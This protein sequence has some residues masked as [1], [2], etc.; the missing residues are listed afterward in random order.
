MLLLKMAL[1]GISSWGYWEFLR[2]KTDLNVYFLPIVTIAVQCSVLFMGGLLHI[3][4]ET[5]I[6]LH[7][8]GLVLAIFCLVSERKLNWKPYLNWGYVCFALCALLVAVFV[9]GKVFTHIDNFSHWSLVVKKILEVNRYPSFIDTKLGYPYYPL[10]SASYIYFFCRM[11]GTEESMQMLAQGIMMLSAVMPLH[12]FAKKDR[13]FSGLFVA[14]VTALIF[15]YAIRVTE[16]L[17]DTLLPLVGMAAV[18]YGLTAFWGENKPDQQGSRALWPLVPM[19]IW[20]AQIKNSGL[21]FAVLAVV[22]VLPRLPRNR[23]GLQQLVLLV[24]S[25]LVSVFLWRSHCAEV[26]PAGAQEKHTVSVMNYAQTFSQKDMGNAG[27]IAARIVQY[28]MTRDAFWWI[29]IWLAVLGVMSLV[30]LRGRLKKYGY[31]LAGAAALHVIY[32][33]GVVGMFLFSMP[34]EEAMELASIERYVRTLDVAEYY[35]MALYAVSLISSVEG[36]WLG[37]VTAAALCLLCFVTLKNVPDSRPWMTLEH[38]RM[39]ETKIWEYDLQP[40][41]EYF[42]CIPEYDNINNFKFLCNYLL[43][44][45][46]DTQVVKEKAELDRA[47]EY[48]ILINLDEG[49]A[50][51]DAWIAENFPE[52]AGASVVFLP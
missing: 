6:G 52:Q 45:L 30:L 2:K 40:G 36:K 47:R 33:G 7:L 50:L 20:I 13:A 49:N 38:R 34:F 41:R 39:L 19:L 22:V 16:L 43:D 11:T 21:L 9:R 15:G 14:A 51:V 48:D 5:A 23:A 37:K 44:E 29:V 25:P 46:P 26:F 42:L 24:A 31:L 4:Q 10:G 1:F 18:L 28:M 17:V 8:I 3:L 27:S 35:L 32:M 12:A